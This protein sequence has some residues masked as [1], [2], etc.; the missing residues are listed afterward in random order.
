MDLSKYLLKYMQ[1]SDSE[2][3]DY[4]ATHSE[5]E[6]ALFHNLQVKRF[7]SLAGVSVHR[8]KHLPDSG[9]TAMHQTEILDLVKAANKQLKVD[10]HLSEVIRLG[11][12]SRLRKVF[13]IFDFI[14]GRMVKMSYFNKQLCLLFLFDLDF[15]LVDSSLSGDLRL[16]VSSIGL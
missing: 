1:G 13:S 15:P 10:R 7:L 2:L 4:V 16:K 8:W 6:R 5:T 11:R 3:I 9:F 14:T 12:R